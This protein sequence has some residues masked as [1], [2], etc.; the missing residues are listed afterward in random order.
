MVSFNLLVSV[1][2]TW[3]NRTEDCK[4][5]VILD[6]L[7]A[8]KDRATSANEK[9]AWIFAFGN[10][11]AMRLERLSNRFFTLQMYTNVTKCIGIRW[12]IRE[13]SIRGESL[14][15]R[16]KHLVFVNLV[17][18]VFRTYS[19]RFKQRI[20]FHVYEIPYKFNKKP[21]YKNRPLPGIW[22]FNKSIP[23][24]CKLEHEVVTFV[25]RFKI[26]GFVKFVSTSLARKKRNFLWE[27][28]PIAFEQPDL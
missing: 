6:L 9:D 21:F 3:E 25:S 13:I 8:L 20:K 26:I 22:K 24:C 14:F 16:A 5:R 11:I 12:Q 19:V 7:S 15:S 1:N 10:G 17:E 4:Q 2:N 27:N 18:F 23:L 28:S